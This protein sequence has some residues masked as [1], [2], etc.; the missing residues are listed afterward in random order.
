MHIKKRLYFS[1]QSKQTNPPNI[2]K[3]ELIRV[4][5]RDIVIPT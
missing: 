3:S 2:I 5:I 1:P 4:P